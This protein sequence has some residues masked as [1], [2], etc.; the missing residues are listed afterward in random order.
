[1]FAWGSDELLE[2]DIRQA[3]KSTRRTWLAAGGQV[4]SGLAMV[5]RMRE[6]GALC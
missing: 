1:M 4:W 5:S 6:V 3:A 2:G